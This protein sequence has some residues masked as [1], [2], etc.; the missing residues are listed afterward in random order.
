MQHAATGHI[1]L[2]NIL[3]MFIIK[4]FP[5]IGGK[6]LG[7]QIYSFLHNLEEVGYLRWVEGKWCCDSWKVIVV[8]TDYRINF[9]LM[10]TS[11]IVC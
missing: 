4:N 10:Y 9:I 2:H 11:C 8:Y 6:Y 5:F 1:Y 3:V 7:I